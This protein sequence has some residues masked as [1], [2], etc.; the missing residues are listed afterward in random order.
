MIGPH[1]IFYLDLIKRFN[2]EVVPFDGLK[3]Q[4]RQLCIRHDVDHDIEKALQI[5]D[6]ERNHG[7]S[8]TYFLLHTAKY[9]QDNKL[10][11]K[12]CDRLTRLGH[13]IGF[14]N[15]ALTE[16]FLHSRP[17]SFTVNNALNV[18][19]Y[20]GHQIDFT[21]SHGSRE[22]RE[23]GFC[24][25]EIWKECKKKKVLNNPQVSLKDVNL[26]EV[27]FMP[28]NF[29]LSESGS[30]WRGG[31]PNGSGYWFERDFPF[32]KRQEIY[33]QVDAFAHTKSAAAQLLTHPKWWSL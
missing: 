4:G 6:F 10:L 21:A 22:G 24:N 5:A 19:R 17:I 8:S 12:S 27:Y 25:F 16:W 31:I 9:F 11:R 1:N 29:Y 20:N 23:L 3:N 26:E 30:K 28:F 33:D 7:I 15:N 18:L 13:S 2:A 32:L 14:H